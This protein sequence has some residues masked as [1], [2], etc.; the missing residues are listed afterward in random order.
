MRDIDRG[1]PNVDD[2]AD[3][4]THL[5]QIITNADPADT[6]AESP[7]T[8]SNPGLTGDAEPDQGNLKEAGS[9]TGRSPDDLATDR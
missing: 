5:R 1:D 7:W 8:A 4:A 3:E 9:G 2:T 6:D